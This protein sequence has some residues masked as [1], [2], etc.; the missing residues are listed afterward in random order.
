MSTRTENRLITIN[1]KDAFNYNNGT[2]KSDVEF[3]FKGLIKKERDILALSIHLTDAQIPVSFYNITASNNVLDYHTSSIAYLLTIPKGNYNFNTLSTIMTSLFL[4]NGHN[5]TITISKTT[6]VIT[7][8]KDTGNFTIYDTYSKIYD[9]IGFTKGFNYGSTNSILTAQYPLNLLGTT[10]IKIKSTILSTYSYDSSS[11]GL[12]NTLTTIPVNEPSFGLIIHE[13]KSTSK[14]L[15][16]VDIVDEFDIQI[17]DQNDNPIDFNNMDWTIS[18]ILEIEREASAISTDDFKTIIEKHRLII[19]QQQ[20]NQNTPIQSSDSIQ[21]DD[22]GD[23]LY[24]N[25]NDEIKP[26]E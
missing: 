19:A 26:V 18:F 15:L 23:Y 11:K 1:S 5:F 8:T 21:T 20:N 13:N 4:A 7:F 16:R 10:K 3:F 6:G 17:T 24:D 25:Q 9:V 22:L 12:S 14:F 2:Y